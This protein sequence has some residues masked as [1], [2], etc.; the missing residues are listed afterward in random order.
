MGKTK[1]NRIGTRIPMPCQPAAE[2][3]HNFQEVAL[4]YSHEEALAEA[5]RCLQCKKPLCVHGCPVE[6]RIPE[7]IAALAADDIDSAYQII[8]STNSLPA[9]CGRVCP[10]ENQCE[11]SCILNAKG[12]PI[13]IGRLERYIAD[14]FISTSSCEELTGEESCPC[15]NTQKKVACIGSGPASLTVAGYL[16]T[17]GIKV[18]VFEALHEPG[19]VL[20]YGIPEFRLPKSD[21]VAKEINTLRSQHVD[22]VTNW[23]GGRTFSIEDLFAEGY[24]AVFIGVGAGLPRFLNIPGEN[25]VGVFSANEYLTRVNLGRAYRFPEFDTPIYYGKNVTVFGGGNVA[26]DAARTAKRLGAESVRIIYRRTRNEMPAR[27][28]ELEHAEEEGIMLELLVSPQ[29]F[30]ADEHGRLAAVT[31]QRMELGE[32]DASGRCCPH[33]IEGNYYDLP[34][35]LAIIAVGTRPNPLLLEETPELALDKR[36]YIQVDK[37]TSETSIANVFAGGDIVTGAATVILAMGAGRKAA[38]EIARRLGVEE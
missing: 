37:E 8:K 30:K 24:Q 22:F 17:R 1:S 20:I 38:R 4:G 18:T 11:G 15:I 33:P 3:I 16:S 23:V 28:E 34:T 32:P 21:V 36:G 7:F 13:A 12:Q 31:L 14:A 9:V 29:E 10:Q 5:H 19:G 2:R 26:M 35:D 6:V 25:F 27:L